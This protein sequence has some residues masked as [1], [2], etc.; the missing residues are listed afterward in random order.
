[1]LH[2][3]T[4]DKN[5]CIPKEKK[6]FQITLKNPWKTMSQNSSLPKS[7]AIGMRNETSAW[8]NVSS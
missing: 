7:S 5:K 8:R 2:P 6:K 3:L 4:L 1:M